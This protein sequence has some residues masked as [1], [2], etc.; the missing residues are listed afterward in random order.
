MIWLTWRQFRGQAVVALAA[1][2]VLTAY[3]VFLGVRLRDAYEQHVECAGCTL[4]AARQA[5]EKGYAT[6]VTL[7]GLLILVA[8]AVI[9]AFWGAPLIARELE[10][11]TYRLVWNQSVTRVRWLAVKL[12]VVVA[13]AVAVTGALSLL[14][15]WAASPYDTL[16]G[17]RFEP[18]LFPA[19]NVAPLG[20]ALF[21]VVAGVA[22]GLL[23]RRTVVAMAITLAVFTAL[24]ILMP[25]V[26]R[27][28]LQPPVTEVVLFRSEA[29]EG[30]GI[31]E[32]GHVSVQGYSVPGAWMLTF[33]GDLRDA[34]G[35]LVSRDDVDRCFTG[36]YE[37]DVACLDAMNL[38][39]TAE[40]Q[41]AD[42]YWT[43]QWLESGIYVLLA[44]LVAGFTFWRIR[45]SLN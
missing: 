14:L 22:I 2:A 43:F 35:E 37:Q 29:A 9:G 32:E 40:Y 23:A 34:A 6:Q 17:H 28:H 18:L 45:R 11:G 25:A 5:L 4:S 3:L 8:P 41:P 15:T 39:Y 12:G 31:T 13:A 42:R 21:A 36:I 1:L 24:Q 19:R 20:Y 38:H 27:P 16:F 7:A 44:G 10:T 33:T 30:I 26:V